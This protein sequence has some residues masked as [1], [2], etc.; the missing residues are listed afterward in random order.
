MTI[1][2][3]KCGVFLFLFLFLKKKTLKWPWE[4]YFTY[5]FVGSVVSL[6]MHVANGHTVKWWTPILFAPGEGSNPTSFIHRLIQNTIILIIYILNYTIQNEQI[7]ICEPNL[8]FNTFFLKQIHRL[9]RVLKLHWCM[10]PTIIRLKSHLTKH[11]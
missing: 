8:V 3:A 7:Q 11:H 2:M 9:S 1:K 10:S 5:F 6:P 4:C